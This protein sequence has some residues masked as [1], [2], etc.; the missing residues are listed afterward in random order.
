MP[1]VRVE[2]LQ[3]ALDRLISEGRITVEVSPGRTKPT[4]LY[5]LIERLPVEGSRAS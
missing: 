4:R 3:Q 5:R 2:V 1:E